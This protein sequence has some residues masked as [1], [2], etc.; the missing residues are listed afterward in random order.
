[1]TVLPGTNYRFNAVPLKIPMMSCSNRKTH[2]KI[3]MESQ[4]TLN[5]ANHLDKEKPTLE[6]SLCVLILKLTTEFQES[7]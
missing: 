2:P 3:H 1:M 5:N 6:D 4:G 7:I